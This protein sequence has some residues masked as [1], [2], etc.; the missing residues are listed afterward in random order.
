MKICVI[1]GGFS[2]EREV[3]LSSGKAI[4]QS[5]KNLGHELISFDLTKDN[6]LQMILML[7]SQKPDCIFNAL[8]GTFGEDGTIQGIFESCNIPYTHSNV[9]SSALAFDK[10]KSKYLFERFGI[11]TPEWILVPINILKIQGTNFPKPFFMKPIAQG[12]TIGV[13]LIETDDDLNNA[14][15]NWDFGKNALLERCI[16]GREMTVSILDDDILGTCELVQ[17]RDKFSTYEAKYTEELEQRL[18][19]A[20]ITPEQEK[21][22][23]DI[24]RK[25]YDL[26]ECSGLAR[27]DIIFDGKDF[28]LLEMNTQPGLTPTSFATIKVKQRGWTMDDLVQKMIDNALKNAA[29]IA[30]SPVMA[31]FS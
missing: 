26:L 24:T 10:V 9:L 3:S 2:S 5:V 8:H 27:S 31:K 13:T 12:S 19:P 18:V 6:I 17:M 20:P 15:K 21:A 23:K 29:T 30:P 4:E 25:A 14:L 11:K 28:Y 7:H 22:I 16:H 1:K